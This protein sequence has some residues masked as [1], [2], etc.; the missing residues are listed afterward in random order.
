MN[1]SY[2][3]TAL[4]PLFSNSTLHV[5]WE[6]ITAWGGGTV[7]NYIEYQGLFNTLKFFST[8][9]SSDVVFRWPKY[10]ARIKFGCNVWHM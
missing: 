4:G 5:T 9:S 2:R 8:K 3:L 1:T 7:Q 6:G 10:E